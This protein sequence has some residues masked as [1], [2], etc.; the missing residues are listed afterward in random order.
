MS[1]LDL[2]KTAV[3]SRSASFDS[4]A[5]TYDLRAGLSE[6]VCRQVVRSVF[7]IARIQ[8]GDLIL[9]IGAGTGLIGQWFAQ[10][11]MQYLG[12]DLSEGM[13]EKFRQRLDP[14]RDNC[15]FLVA[16]GDQKWAI[17]SGTVRVIFSSRAIHLLTPEHL[18]DEI[19]RVALPQGAA[20]LIGRVQRQKNSISTQMKQQM[21]H[22][23]RQRGFQPR[24]GEKNS[25]ELISL[26]C[27]RG[28][29]VIDSEIVA[30]WTVLN[31]PQQSLDS[32]RQKPGL[33]GIDLLQDVQQP[34]LKELQ[35][36]AEET[37]GG[38]DRSVESEETYIL[39][40]VR[41]NN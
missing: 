35:L 18:V 32:W 34:I 26:C 10:E 15:Q 9:E 30:R 29:K 17:A 19:F 1:A 31:T 37:F 13:L 33:A 8:P 7:A 41:L 5:E 6:E 12:L 23:L 14:Q 39:Q 4:Q 36:W 2:S 40:G 25:K 21:H 22:L 28:A 27:Q 38:L 3:K 20:L 24:E 16:D 11:P